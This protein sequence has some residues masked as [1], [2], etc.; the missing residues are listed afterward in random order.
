MLGVYENFPE[1]VHKIVIFASPISSKRL[2]QT[3]TE[4][5]HKLNTTTLRL[6]DISAPSVPECDVIFEF[7][8]AEDENFTYLDEE[9]KEKVQKKIR[10]KPFQTM[11][12]LCVIRYYRK[13]NGK[14]IPLK[15]DYYMLRF[16][17]GKGLME[18]Q[19]YH[20]RGSM[21][22]A[23]EELINLVRGRINEMFHKKILKVVQ[24]R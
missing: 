13:Q 18:M 2:Q 16:M 8:I 9:E 15:F 14:K 12:F 19:V 22:V 23:P 7:G 1:N 6:E 4:I 3:V 10:E 20:E 11:D 24:N 17:C 21:H 5:F